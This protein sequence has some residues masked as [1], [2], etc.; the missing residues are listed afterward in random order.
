MLR[1]QMMS[2]LLAVRGRFNQCSIHLFWIPACYTYTLCGAPHL[3]S[4]RNTKGWWQAKEVRTVKTPKG[5]RA[6]KGP[7]W[8][9]QVQMRAD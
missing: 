7:T 4:L 1:A 5:S 6:S 3:A 8:V 9:T 2:I